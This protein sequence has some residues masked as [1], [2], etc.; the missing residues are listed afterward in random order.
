MARDTTSPEVPTR[1]SARTPKRRAAAPPGPG[2]QALDMGDGDRTVPVE[3]LARGLEADI[4]AGL[5]ELLATADTAQRIAQALEAIPDHWHPGSLTATVQGQLTADGV[6]PAQR[7]VLT[8]VLTILDGLGRQSAAISREV[9][10]ALAGTSAG[11]VSHRAAELEDLGYLQRR[12]GR[13]RGSGGK[14]QHSTLYGRGHKLTARREGARCDPDHRAPRGRAV[15]SEPPRAER[16][17]GPRAERAR[18]R[19]ETS[20]MHGAERQCQ[21]DG[22]S[23]V[24]DA[25]SYRPTDLWCR[26]CARAHK[27]R[28]QSTR[29]RPPMTDDAE[30]RYELRQRTEDW[31]PCGCPPSGHI[32]GCDLVDAGDDVDQDPPDP[33]PTAV[34]DALE[35]VRRIKAARDKRPL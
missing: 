26:S 9:I 20:S 4:D 3:P 10:A 30:G 13:R 19:D 33:G 17:R 21:T 14:R 12:P 1:A 23:T 6:T 11:H 34:S 22:C 8:A 5:A 29:R 35:A 28:Q 24:L 15:D 18:D 31:Q 16:A 32:N 2:Q 25:D 7:A 27:A